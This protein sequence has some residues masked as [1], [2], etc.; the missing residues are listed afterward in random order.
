MTCRK[1]GAEMG[2]ELDTTPALTMPPRVRSALTGRNGWMNEQVPMRILLNVR[3][4]TFSMSYTQKVSRWIKRQQRRRNQTYGRNV[5]PRNERLRRRFL[6]LLPAVHL[7][8]SQYLR[9]AFVFQPPSDS[10][11]VLP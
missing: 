6:S 3:Q 10:S 11:T 1:H 8:L 2:V 7:S 9:Q 4:P 5:A